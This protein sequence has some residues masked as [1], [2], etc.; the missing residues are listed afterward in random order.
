[1]LARRRRGVVLVNVV[2]DLERKQLSF[3]V[4]P[5]SGSETMASKNSNDESVV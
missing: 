3:A 2:F 5:V 4:E 1:M